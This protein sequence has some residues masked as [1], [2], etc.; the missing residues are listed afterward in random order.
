LYKNQGKY[1][2]A[3]SLYLEALEMRRRLFTGDHPAVATSLNNLAVLY[4][5][6]GKYSEAEFLYLEALAMFE[7]VLGTN[8]P[9]TIT[10]WDN[11]RLLQQQ[12]IPPPFYI[13]LLNNLIAVLTL[14]LHRLWLL[15]KRIII[16][17]WR[18]F[19]R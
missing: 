6:Q 9:N 16:F 15:I 3:E 13:R 2:K 18:L 7:R 4:K 14:L 8:H 19:R 10:V 5:N 11:L 12:L 1:S 17:S